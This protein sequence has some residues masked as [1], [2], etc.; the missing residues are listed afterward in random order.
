MLALV[1]VLRLASRLT[2]RDHSSLA[3]A[4]LTWNRYNFVAGLS[5]SFAHSAMFIALRFQEVHA[6]SA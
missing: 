6:K 1:A 3:K 5:D 2:I 4:R